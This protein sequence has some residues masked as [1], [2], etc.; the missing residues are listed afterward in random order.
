MGMAINWRSEQGQLTKDNRDCCGIGLRH[1]A[2]L[3]VVLDGSTT[4]QDSGELARLIA[5]NL[6]VSFVTADAVT[7]ENY[8]LVLVPYIPISRCG[9][10]RVQR[11]S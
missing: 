5:R 11:A 2:S 10:E 7:V 8:P 6:V 4:G 9:F 3:L 1:D